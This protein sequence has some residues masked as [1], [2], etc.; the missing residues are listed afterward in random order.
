M[1]TG[2]GAGDWAGL[3]DA[4]AAQRLAA[5][6][7]NELAAVRRRDF[8][9]IA[10]D[11]F[12]EPMLLILIALGGL[13]LLIGNT[14]DAFLL[15]LFVFVIIGITLYQERKTE[16]AIEALRDLS[17]PRALVVRSG[18][19]IMIAGREVV[20]GDILILS[21]GNRVAADALLLS[22]VNLSVDESLLTGESVPVSKDAAPHDMP[23][24]TPGGDGLPS[25]Y[26]GTL[27][28]RGQG[29]ARV[30]AVGNATELGKIG[31]MLQHGARERTVLHR[32][33]EKLVRQIT[34]AAVA[35]CL[36]VIVVYGL[37]RHD[38]LN[39]FLA[40]LTLAMALLPEEFPVVLMVFLALG[41]WRIAAQHVLTRRIPA[42]EALG[43]ITV[44]CVDKTGTLT[45][46]RMAVRR[47]FAGGAAAEFAPGRPCSPAERELV[48]AAALAGKQEPVDPMEKAIAQ[49][50]GTAPGAGWMMVRE[51][52]RDGAMFAMSCAWR[53]GAGDEYVVAAKGAPESIIDLCHLDTAQAAS[54]LAAAGAMAD[55]GLRVIG[56]ARA[57]ING[58][59]LP[60]GQH[61]F[62][63][64]F[65]GLI[66]LE[67]PVRDSVPGAVQ[68]CLRAGVRIVMITGDY[69]R[70]AQHVADRI[71]LPGGGRIITGAEMAA[72]DD[73]AFRAC[74]RRAAIFARV[75]PEQKLRIVQALKDN[76]EVVAMTGDGVNDAPAL[77]YADV[78][79]AMGGRGTDVAREAAGIVLVN[80]DFASIVRTIRLGR[81]I[82][83]NIRKAMAYILAIHVPIAG[84]T[85]VPVLA[86]WPLVLLPVHIV[87]MQ[88]II[89][90]ASS[91]AFEA[92][93]EEADIMRRPPEALRKPLFGP[94][95]IVLSLLQGL[96]VFVIVL[97][98]YLGAR[99]LGKGFAEA[100]TLAFTTLIAGNVSLI[101]SNRSWHETILGTF[102]ALNRTLWAVVG[103][104]VGILLLVL[105]LPFLRRLFHFD[106]L[107]VPDIAL[108]LLAGIL[109]IAW[110]E[111]LKRLH[112]RR[113]RRGMLDG[114]LDR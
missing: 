56:V 46:N 86:G 50:W 24:G 87:F 14:D 27:V 57:R 67:D 35:V 53:T 63:F 2:I 47:L 43:S 109:S 51:Y 91:I 4:A 17:S 60:D 110:F 55:E 23:L 30:K 40:G 34:L 41:A 21:E 89:D 3:S 45:S 19:R 22:A 13:Y 97:A 79:I 42:V 12:R 76:G 36:V 16:R 108:C 62:A 37:T 59:M 81:R 20:R 106:L 61:D 73:A 11:V 69:P 82:F 39:G 44:L 5:E 54:F 111:G 98:V 18:R 114:M 7:Y 90:P 68:E 104:A 32:Q 99:H 105:Y 25:V 71:G 103:G 1:A 84:L 64:S 29:V 70:T 88:L 72:M 100:R 15:F 77:K 65:L 92:E 85:L 6:G 66:G 113:R 95:A 26:S 10:R 28:V 101:L 83:D 74:S 9:A 33:T 107:H 80:D 49:A 31:G 93:P 38:W 78:G 94:G 52:P 96:S 8:F 112:R 58:E 48:E 102:R 75:V